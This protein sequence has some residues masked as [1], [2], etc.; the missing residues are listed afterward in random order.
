MLATSVGLWLVSWRFSK[1]LRVELWLVW[2]ENVVESTHMRPKFLP[3]IWHTYG[4]S[5]ESGSVSSNIQVDFSMHDAT[6][7]I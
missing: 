1:S 2:A 7:E 4:R 6:H 3:Q 5:R